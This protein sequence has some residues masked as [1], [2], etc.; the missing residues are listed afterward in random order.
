MRINISRSRSGLPCL[1]ESGGALTSS[2]HATIIADGAGYPK[3]AIRVFTRGELCNG[4]HAIIPI[5]VGDIVVKV[6]T[7]HDKTAVTVFV[8]SAIY[9]DGAELE[10]CA[11]P[12][13]EDAIMAAIAK[14]RDFH[15]RR[16]FYI[17]AD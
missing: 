13:A 16:P 2:G 9:D 3:R 12:I 8:I 17:K 6:E 11:T 4:D 5:R 14:A 1:C 15:C 10:P 7:H